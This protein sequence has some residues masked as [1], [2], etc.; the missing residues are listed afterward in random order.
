[1]LTSIR[2]ELIKQTRRPANWLLLAIAAVLTLTFAYAIPYAGLS[3]GPSGAPGS[4]RGLPSMLPEAFVGNALGGVPIFV[5]ALA[6]VFG[7]LVAGSEYGF[8]TW[9][10]VLAQRPSRFTAYGSKLAVVAIANLIGVLTLFAAAAG[11][12]AAVAALEGAPMNWPSAGDI[13][14]GMGVG[15]L[16]MTMWGACGALLGIAFRS[17][18]LPIGLGLV[19]M[20]AIQ[21]LLA[22]IAAPALEFVGELQKVLPGPNT[23]ALAA[24][25]GAASETPGVDALVGSGHA[26]IVV[27]GYLVAFCALGGWLMHRRDIL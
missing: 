27:A 23:G 19:W 14:L 25:M 16:V 7:V 9:K 6:L 21:N 18:A 15:W 11:G 26:T 17:V 4:G 10:T 3:S 12:S 5:G 1:M 24:A 8:Q 22:S 20:L 2:A 13:V